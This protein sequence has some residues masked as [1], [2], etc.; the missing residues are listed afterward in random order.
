MPF[1]RQTGNIAESQSG[2]L[3]RFLLLQPLIK[4][5]STRTRSACEREVSECGYYPAKNRFSF[6]TLCLQLAPP[7]WLKEDL[8]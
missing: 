7:Q 8:A 1:L 5:W 3:Q 4:P 2:N 6:V